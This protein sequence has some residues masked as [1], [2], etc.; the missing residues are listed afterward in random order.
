MTCIMVSGQYL[1]TGSLKIKPL[2]SAFANFHCVNNLTKADF[3]LPNGKSLKGELK[4][5]AQNLIS[6]LLSGRPQCHSGKESSCRRYGC[7]FDPW[8]RK[9]PWRRKWQI[10]PVLFPGNSH[11][12]RTLVSYSPWGCKESDTSYQL[13]T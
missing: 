9:I 2:F 10:T 1:T 6:T 11:G 4:R 3:N 7:G 12:Q 13:S 5:D 8:V